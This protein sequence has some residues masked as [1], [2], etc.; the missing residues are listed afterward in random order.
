MRKKT[1]IKRVKLKKKEWKLK[2]KSFSKQ[3]N[4]LNKN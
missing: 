3:P 1:Y 4:F 2:D